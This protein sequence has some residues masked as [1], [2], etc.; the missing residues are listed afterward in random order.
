MLMTNMVVV[1]FPFFFVHTEAKKN[2]YT[3][4]FIGIEYV[5]NNTFIHTYIHTFTD[6]HIIKNRRIRIEQ[7]L[8]LSLFKYFQS[9]LDV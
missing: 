9:I 6:H 1:W 2:P 8:K 3:N 4:S 5:S 7:M